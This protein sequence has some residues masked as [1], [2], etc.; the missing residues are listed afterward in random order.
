MKA[1]SFVFT[2]I[3][4]MVLFIPG[5]SPAQIPSSE[6][7]RPDLEMNGKSSNEYSPV[8]VVIDGKPQPVF[9]P[10]TVASP[11]DATTQTSKSVLTP[12]SS[13]NQSSEDNSASTNEK[14]DQQKKLLKEYLDSQKAQ[15]KPKFD[16]DP[17]IE[18]LK[19]NKAEFDSQR[20]GDDGRSASL[21][22]LGSA[23]GKILN[24]FKSLFG[25]I[26]DFTSG[27]FS[28]QGPE[29]STDCTEQSNQMMNRVIDLSNKTQNM[30]K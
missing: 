14:P 22:N 1:N 15:E 24:F 4:I 7:D 8:P 19:K 17:V 5:I 21:G 13:Q 20:K 11:K 16:F 2:V 18:F 12:V 30:K 23:I 3:L 26:L 27:L 28:T 9:I 6:S 10:T 25:F 29:F